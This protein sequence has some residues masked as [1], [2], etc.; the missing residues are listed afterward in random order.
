[1]MGPRA[2][3]PMHPCFCPMESLFTCGIQAPQYHPE[4]AKR[5]SSYIYMNKI[6]DTLKQ[7]V[8]EDGHTKTRQKQ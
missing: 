4:C 2:L 3:Y 5:S 6:G 8:E 7:L 1:M